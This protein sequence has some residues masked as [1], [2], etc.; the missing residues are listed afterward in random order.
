MSQEIKEYILNNYQEFTSADVLKDTDYSYSEVSQTIG[1]MEQQGLIYWSE[2][3]NKYINQTTSVENEAAKNTTTEIIE[4]D[5]ETQKEQLKKFAESIPKKTEFPTLDNGKNPLGFGSDK[6]KVDDVNFITKKLQ[7]IL[8]V[9]NNHL[10]KIY[11]QIGTVYHTFDAL[12]KDY[13][14]RILASLKSAEEA[15]RKAVQGL[16]ENKK[17]VE[18][19]KTVIEVLKKHKA[20]LDELQ[21]LKEID[22]FYDEYNDFK[23]F[24][25]KYIEDLGSTQDVVE[26]KLVLLQDA[27]E[28]T[29]EANQKTVQESKAFQERT[30]KNIQY[31]WAGFIVNAIIVLVLFALIISGVL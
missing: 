8:K 7:G 22:E 16:E 4:R 25:E 29:K 30:D 12:D 9:Q 23:A 1:E 28:V 15:N 5:F 20:E 18:S 10:Q 27:L 21:H 14:Q 17:I 26:G 13:I 19:Q 6:A 3:K 24:Q 31:L 11:N 2:D